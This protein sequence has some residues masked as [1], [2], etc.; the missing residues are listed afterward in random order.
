MSESLAKEG[1]NKNRRD[2]LYFIASS[3]RLKFA[4]VPLG[5]MKHPANQGVPS[6][7][8]IYTIL[9]VCYIRILLTMCHCCDM[10]PKNARI[11]IC[12]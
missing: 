5:H 1:V 2:P 4:L 8:K 7:C 11:T 12:Y 9:T 10:L 6:T 3:R